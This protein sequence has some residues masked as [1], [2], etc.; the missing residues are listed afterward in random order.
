MN[1]LR[2]ELGY[3]KTNDIFNLLCVY[4]HAHVHAHSHD[5]GKGWGGGKKGGDGAKSQVTLNL[6]IIFSSGIF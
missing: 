5:L 1:E 6:T 3:I 2:Y 4:T